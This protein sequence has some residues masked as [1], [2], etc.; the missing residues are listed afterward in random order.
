M[1]NE[2]Q[3]VKQIVLSDALSKNVLKN[4]AYAWALNLGFE[5]FQNMG[6]PKERIRFRQH[7]LDERAFY[8][9][10]A[11]DVEV[12]LNS[13]GWT[14]VCGIHDRT[15]YDLSQHSKHSGKNLVAT[16]EDGKKEM[17]HIIEIA[18][19]TDRPA[20]S[21]LDIF[22]EKKEDGEGKS[23]LHL[24]F[25]ISPVKAAIFPLVKKE[26]VMSMARSLYDE[27][28][29]EIVCRFDASGSIGKRYLRE[30]ESGTPFCITVDFDIEKDN[31]VT[32]RN[33]DTEEQK[34][35]PYDEV[36]SILKQLITGKIKFDKI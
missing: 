30:D 23:T 16:R 20:F 26:P 33:R 34:R 32:I 7:N 24:P 29:E 2:K 21:V 36:R 18:F 13:F 9:D 4:K 25:D 8:A 6:I 12:N 5:L 17:P 3:E 11:W 31:T 22:Y 14:E 10:D 19:G 1:Q 35:I 27:I 15:T 28:R